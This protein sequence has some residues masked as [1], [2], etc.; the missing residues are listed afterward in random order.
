MCTVSFIPISEN[1]YL[2]GSNRDELKTR[3]QAIPPKIQG[4]GSWIAPIDTEAN[5]TWFGVNQYGITLTLINN[6]QAT[7]PL[8]DHRKD[9]KSRGLI[10]PELMPFSN[11]KAVS[12]WFEQMDETNFNPFDV[13]AV[14]PSPMTVI[15]WSWDGKSFQ[16]IIEKPESQIW[17]SAGFDLQKITEFRKQVFTNKILN[18]EEKPLKTLQNF[19]SSQHP[20]PGKFSVAMFQD[21]VQTVSST[22]VQVGNKKIEGLYF[23]GHP[24]KNG[25][26]QSFK[27]ERK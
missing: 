16:K 24:L 9:A 6:Y 23:D 14:F 20:E 21:E 19:H 7:N 2:I 25:D 27:Y 15:R 5:G 4:D 22:L 18:S 11:E 13:I 26:W 3:A 12:D 10:I 17:V 1:Q 8:L